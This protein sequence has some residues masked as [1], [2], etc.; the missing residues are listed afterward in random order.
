MSEVGSEFNPTKPPLGRRIID[1]AAKPFF[2]QEVVHASADGLRKATEFVQN[3]GGL[4]VAFTHLSGREGPDVIIWLAG[5]PVFNTRRVV[6]PVSHHTYYRS[7][8]SELAYKTEAKIAGIELKPVVTPETQSLAGNNSNIVPSQGLKDYLETAGE[9]L[10][11]RGVV[12][13]ALQAAGNLGKLGDPTP[14]LSALVETT[15]SKFP[16]C[17]LGVLF[18]GLEFPESEGENVSMKGADDVSKM[19]IG[20]RIQLKIG[21]FLTAEEAQKAAEGDESPLTLTSEGK[22][23]RR[24]DSWAFKQLASLLSPRN[25]D[26]RYLPQK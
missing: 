15:K 3:G 14:A 9:A 26:S 7:K 2:P 16:Q 10:S 1:K 19:H 6:S 24:L 23:I 22:K 13:V 18:V 25:V 17:K 12:P 5:Q 21:D 8:L 11:K 20:R 4:I